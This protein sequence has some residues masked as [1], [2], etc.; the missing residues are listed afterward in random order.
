MFFS[1]AFAKY[2]LAE[3]HSDT[4]VKNKDVSLLQ[5]ISGGVA[6]ITE[7]A[8]K[9]VVFI[10]TLKTVIVPQMEYMDPL[11]FFFGPRLRHRQP[12]PKAKKEKR[13]YGQGSGFIVDL[14]KGYIVTNAHVIDNIDDKSDE[15]KVVLA[16]GRQYQVKVLGKDKNTDVAVVQ[17]K[18]SNFD[19]SGL[20]ELKF[21]DSN[22]LRSGNFVVALGAPFGL[23]GSVS[24][25]TISALNRANLELTKVG[26]FIQ[27]DAAINPGNSGGPLL[28]MRG[29][30]VGMNTLIFSQSRGSQGVGFA[31]PSSIVKKVAQT[32]INY[33]KIE[34]GYLG[35]LLQKLND[36]LRLGLKLPEGINGALI[37]KVK[38][39]SAASKGGIKAGDV[40][41]KVE[42][43]VVKHISDLVNII[44]LTKPAT[45]VS[46]VL[47]RRGEKKFLDVIIGSFETLK[48]GGSGGFKQRKHQKSRLVV[49]MKL[50][51]VTGFLQEKY[52]F[53]SRYGLVVTYIENN[54]EAD[55]ANISVGDVILAVNGDKTNKLSDLT[56]HIK[57]GALLVIQIER[58]KSR[59]GEP[60]ITLSVK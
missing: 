13:P 2:N 4:I 52:Q 49:G 29:G 10:T 11:E 32:L 42:R 33:G 60:F 18:Q 8:K 24:F 21:G 36:D 7:Y 6:D 30:V 28:S 38:P 26:D 3:M 31:V 37:A 9:G 48:Q 15:I 44:A 14:R 47:Y 1:L 35:V 51:K 59:M 57:P 16:N 54:S 45:R 34:R 5:R 50:E 43:R 58:T 22:I 40:I 19:R 46:I 17:I 53:E 23:K 20:Q 55:K 41:V 12:H 56:P 39:N 27:T 25:G